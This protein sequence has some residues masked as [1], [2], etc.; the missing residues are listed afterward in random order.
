MKQ[1]DRT[2]NKSTLYYLT[3]E[4]A[5]LSMLKTKQTI[6]KCPR[7]AVSWFTWNSLLY[8]YDHRA[9]GQ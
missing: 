7:A 8:V 3:K 1:S 9:I 6:F 4:T 2:L 5:E